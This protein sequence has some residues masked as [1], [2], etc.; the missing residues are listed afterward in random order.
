MEIK[1]E[2]LAATVCGHTIQ[3]DNS[4]VGHNWRTMHVDDLRPDVA[5]II[6]AE[7]IDGERESGE[8]IICGVHYRWID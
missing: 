2:Y 8:E 3:T 5:N 7:I 1:N 6:A 4:G